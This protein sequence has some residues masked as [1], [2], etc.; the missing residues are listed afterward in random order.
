VLGLAQ[1]IPDQEVVA[2]P[3][4][5]PFSKALAGEWRY[6]RI[7]LSEP[8]K[9]TV[10]GLPSWNLEGLLVGIAARPSG[11][12]DVAGLGQWLADAGHGVSI[13][14][15]IALLRSMGAATRQRVAYLLC[16]SENVD[17]ALAIVDA[18]PPTETAWLG[19]REAGG[20]FDRRSKVN[21]TLLHQYLSVGTGS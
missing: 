11:Y 3:A 1:R 4:D 8:A 13:E 6:V 16:A 2:L 17:G 21:D 12:R 9:T 14:T 19:P 10:D 5:E 18:Y 20:R 15:L 7:E